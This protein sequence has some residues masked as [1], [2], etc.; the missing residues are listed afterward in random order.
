MVSLKY[1]IYNWAM[2][3]TR[4]CIQS[5]KSHRYFLSADEL[6]KTKIV[7]KSLIQSLWSANNGLTSECSTKPTFW[8]VIYIYIKV[9]NGIK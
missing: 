8:R 9:N 6:R 7:M 1:V 5:S 2:F 4:T 3:N